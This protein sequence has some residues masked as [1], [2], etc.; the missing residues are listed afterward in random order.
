MDNPNKSQGKLNSDAQ[1]APNNG[2]LKQNILDQ[3]AEPF[4]AKAQNF[5][6]RSKALA[7]KPSIAIEGSPLQK[8]AVEQSKE[9]NKLHQ[10]K[11]SELFNRFF[12]SKALTPGQ[13]ITRSF[14][15]PALAIPQQLVG[16]FQSRIKGAT[17]RIGTRKTRI[18]EY[19]VTLKTGIKIKDGKSIALT[20]AER[21][22][23]L[24]KKLRSE[25]EL[26]KAKD[27]LRMLRVYLEEA[28]TAN[29]SPMR[30]KIKSVR[31]LSF[32]NR[33]AP[34]IAKRIVEQ[35]EGSPELKEKMLTVKN[36]EEFLEVVKTGDAKTHRMLLDKSKLTTQVRLRVLEQISTTK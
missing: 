36:G 34:S 3:M 12:G 29:Q 16:L 19:R 2:G 17:T 10:T 25:A 8:K 30:D 20:P 7:E 11:P 35:I 1:S 5:P 6:G 33:M 18:Q 15:N 4:S 31:E 13:M 21:K 27:D 26:I 23:I 22:S 32:I 9:E 14:D 28:M 24:D